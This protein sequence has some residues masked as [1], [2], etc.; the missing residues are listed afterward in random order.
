[1]N[2]DRLKALSPAA[3]R[4]VIGELSDHDANA[5]L[6]DWEFWARPAQLA[7]LGDWVNWLILAGRGFGKTRVGT[8][9]VRRWAK[10]FP[11]VNLIGP[12]A[13]DVRDVMVQG[14]G[15]GSAILEVC[16]KDEAP[17]YYP[18]EGAKQGTGRPP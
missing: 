2:A 15:A 10:E 12:T 11:I 1:M 9:Q 16:R 4:K 5:I 7:P 3:L 14:I 18:P 13:A 17:V 6:Y 8:E